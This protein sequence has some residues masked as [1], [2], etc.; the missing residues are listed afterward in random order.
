MPVVNYAAAA[1]L[2]AL[3]LY[4][5]VVGKPILLPLVI[6]I[7]VWYLIN[8]LAAVFE[9]VQIHEQALPAI[10]RFGAAILVLLGLLW[11]VVNLVIGNINQVAAAAP[12]YEENL[13]QLLERV[14]EWLGMD[15]VPTIQALFEGVN[16]TDLIRNLAA[17]IT[18]IIGNA[19]TM[20]IYVAFLLL[21]QSSFNKKIAALFPDAKREAFVHRII[22]RI[23]T[24]IQ[25][26][27]WLKTLTSLLTGFLSY[28]VM[29]MVGVDFA[30]FWALLIFAL[31]YIPY[32]GALLGV[33]FPTLLTL[34]QFDTLTPFF[35]VA[36]TLTLIQFM[37][38]N[39]LEPRIMG[40]GLN[41][42][43]LIMLLSL[44]VWGS[45]WGVVG[46]FLAVPLMVVVMIICANF[47]AT[48]PVAIMLSEDGQLHN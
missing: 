33:V 41:I 3:V 27:V 23:A 48:R 20:L 44:A 7:F 17:A 29:K 47:D 35:I 42:S 43:P 6:A 24:E 38:G 4:L 46:M 19:G 11:F 10:A 14:S 9:R 34:V 28:L 15:E 32:I 21:E 37:I 25:T 16:V 2:T 12:S 13:A 45:I 40:K 5:L 26:Y 36:G 22:Q 8:A 31:N 1:A 30:E 39:V 18:G